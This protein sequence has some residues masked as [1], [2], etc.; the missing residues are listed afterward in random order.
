MPKEPQTGPRD[1][2]QDGFVTD[3]NVSPVG[4]GLSP[5]SSSLLQLAK[6]NDSEAW[7]RILFLYSPLVY[8][9]ARR[10]GLS[11]ADAPD[12]CQDV[13][14]AVYSK[15]HEFQKVKPQ[16]SFRS[17]LF[18]ITRNRVYDYLRK[19]GHRPKALGGSDAMELVL[20]V[21]APDD[22]IE[23]DESER[24][25]LL[26]RALEMVR[27]DFEPRTWDAFWKVTIEEAA[28]V[29]VAAS[30][31]ITT[32]AVYLAKSRVLKRLAD[33]FSQLIDAWS[34]D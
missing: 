27:T 20:N 19:D 26:R 30:L 1:A 7:E 22:D 9:W 24:K 16:D 28:A 23:C 34:D 29:D 12:V 31:G 33:Q 25:F 18:T 4:S 15:L 17:W 11:E 13:F 10:T 8:K 6:A 2:A 5:T 21:P 14:K 3:R 32:N